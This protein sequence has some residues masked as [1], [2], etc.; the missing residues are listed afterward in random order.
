METIAH[1]YRVDRR[2]INMV[3]FIFEAYEGVAAVTTLDAAMGTIRVATAPGCEAVVKEVMA[4]LAKTIL[5]EECGATPFI[6]E[7][8]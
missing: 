5:V 2:Q 8:Y 4:D 6:P 7:T 3:K 1:Y